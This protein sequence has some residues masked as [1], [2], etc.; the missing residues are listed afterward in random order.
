MPLGAQATTQCTEAIDKVFFF[1][2]ERARVDLQSCEKLA[3]ERIGKLREFH[4]IS[5]MSG[6]VA[7]HFGNDA[8]LVGTVQFQDQAFHFGAHGQWGKPHPTSESA[9]NQA[10]FLTSDGLI[11]HL[12]QNR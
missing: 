12:F 1:D 5:G 3:V 4:K 11:D 10:K 9:D 6:N 8:W 2:I 7:G